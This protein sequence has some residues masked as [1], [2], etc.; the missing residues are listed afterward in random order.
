M[1]KFTQ[2]YL[3]N[4]MEGVIEGNTINTSAEFKYLN[5]LLA[6]KFPFTLKQHVKKQIS[7]GKEKAQAGKLETLQTHALGLCPVRTSASQIC[8]PA[9]DLG[10]LLFFF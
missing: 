3:E 4:T 5:Q 7:N 9:P 10:P 2:K 6:V 8:R 1:S